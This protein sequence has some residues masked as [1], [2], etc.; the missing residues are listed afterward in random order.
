MSGNFGNLIL[1][2]GANA[3]PVR[4]L[5]DFLVVAGGGGAEH[6]TGGGGAG[7]YRNSFNNE[8]SGRNSSSETA[9]TLEANIT[10]T[11]TVGAGGAGA[12]WP[13]S[14]AAAGSN[15]VISGSDITTVTS[16]GGGQ[17]L[18]I[19]VWRWWFWWCKRR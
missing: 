19:C 15:S 14:V 18:G 9:L 2:L 17:S 13:T 1:G 12:V 7:G 4:Y 3:F 10:Y 5:A 8:T 11:I 16:L 6:N